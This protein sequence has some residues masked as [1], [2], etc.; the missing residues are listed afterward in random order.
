MIRKSWVSKEKIKTILK[1]DTIERDIFMKKLLSNKK[2]AI[3]L[4]VATVILLGFYVYM[5]ARPISYGMAYHN[6]SEYAGGVFEGTMKFYSDETMTN[7]NTNFYDELNSRYY[8][9]DGYVFFTMADTDEKYEEEVDFINKNF[10]EAIK[11]PFYADEINAFRVVATEG[12]GFE[13]VYTCTPAIVFA[14]TVGIV[15]AALIGL[16]SASWL[17]FTKKVTVAEAADAK[18][19]ADTED[20]AD[21]ED[22]AGAE[23][24][25]EA[26]ECKSDDE[27]N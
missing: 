1:T 16:T 7:S 23:E 22:V 25:A 3:A 27:T 26:E 19:A 9:K 15:I 10:D 21:A 17:L 11:M 2:T 5:L 4:L 12:D 6:K 14:I 18:E 24:A 20:A 13:T 8:Y